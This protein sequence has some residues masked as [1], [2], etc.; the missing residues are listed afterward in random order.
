MVEKHKLKLI[1]QERPPLP[2]PPQP[3]RGQRKDK[4]E[5]LPQGKAAEERE[6]EREI[7]KA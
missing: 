5:S 4:T 7:Q 2:P 3:Q 6:I 1:P